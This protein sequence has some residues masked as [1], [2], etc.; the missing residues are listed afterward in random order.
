MTMAQRMPPER[1]VAVV[2]HPDDAELLAY[3]TLRRYR[4][5]GATVTVLCL[6]HGVNGVSLVDAARGTR[7][8]ERERINEAQAAWDGTGVEVTCLGLPDGALHPDRELISLVESDLIA[9]ECTT[10]ITHSPNATN[11][12]QDHLALGAAATNAA[13]RVATCHTVLYGEP[14]APYSGFAPTILVDITDFL[15]DKIEALARHT[16]QRGRWYLRGDYIRHRAADAAWR[17]HPSF[18]A[19]GAAFEAF[20][21]PLLT[22]FPPAPGT[23]P[24][25]HVTTP[26]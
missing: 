16:S 7:L 4:K 15:D 2:A 23:C 1:V 13:A 3:G 24:A 17:L 8:T 10:L 11:D 22:L 21:T 18:A 6:T 5:V 14:H 19:Q 20:E 9:R 25:D 26:W 12:H